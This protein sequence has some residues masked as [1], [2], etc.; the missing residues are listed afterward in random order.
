[1]SVNSGEQ[2]LLLLILRPADPEYGR[3]G[4]VGGEQLM[5]FSYHSCYRLQVVQQCDV[6]T[7]LSD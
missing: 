4:A 6:A 2:I 1:M 3:Q 5:S 7:A